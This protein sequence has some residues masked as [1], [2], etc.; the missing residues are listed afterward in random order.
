[1]LE[2]KVPGVTL[3]VYAAVAAPVVA[4]IGLWVVQRYADR[5]AAEV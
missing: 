1:M 5:F 3:L 4:V 2:G